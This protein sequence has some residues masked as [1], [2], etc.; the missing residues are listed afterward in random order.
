MISYASG[1]HEEQ[2]IDFPDDE[3]LSATVTDSCGQR[4]Y[5]FRR[6][7]VGVGGWRGGGGVAR[8]GV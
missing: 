7:S 8:G 2:A 6:Q 1:Q 3:Y 5:R 4:G